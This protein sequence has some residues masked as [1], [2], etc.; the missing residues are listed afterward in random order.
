MIYVFCMSSYSALHLCEVLG[1]NLRRYQSYRADTNDG[2]VDRRRTD[3]QNFG[4]YNGIIPSPL[5]DAG[6]KKHGKIIRCI[7]LLFGTNILMKKINTKYMYI[8]YD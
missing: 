7:R 2:S 4:L 6:H 3:T 1:K 5:F 8:S